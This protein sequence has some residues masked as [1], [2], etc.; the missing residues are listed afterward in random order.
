MTEVNPT[1]AALSETKLKPN[2]IISIDIPGFNSVHNPSQT[3]SGGV[4][5]YIN[6]K[7]TYQLRIDL[8]LQNV[9]CEIL[10]I[11]SPTSS[12]KP[13]I[14]GVIYRHPIHAFPPLQNE[15]I[16]LFTHLQNKNCE[17]LIGEI[18]TLIFLSIMNNLM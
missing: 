18:L 16:K 9:G 15:F 4:G 1:F 14:I 17:Y 8:N 12:G 11:E 3:N 5:F 2:F 10:F 6:S 7:L 13:F